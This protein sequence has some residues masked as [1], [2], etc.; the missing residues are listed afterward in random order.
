MCFTIDNKTLGRE[1]FHKDIVCYKVVIKNEDGTYRP[2]LIDVELILPWKL[3]DTIIPDILGLP[4]EEH[5]YTNQTGGYKQIRHGINSFRM[6]GAN[7]TLLNYFGLQA[8]QNIERWKINATVVMLKCIIPAGT[9]YFLNYYEFGNILISEKLILVK[10][11]TQDQYFASLSDETII[12]VT[13]M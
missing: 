10:E 11:V 8:C 7:T 4:I 2:S 1:N 3:G 9:D 12:S 13:T 6:N 5:S